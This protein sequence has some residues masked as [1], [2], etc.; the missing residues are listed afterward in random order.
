[1]KKHFTIML[2]TAIACLTLAPA[3]YART[4]DNC[5]PVSVSEPAALL[6]SLTALGLFVAARRRKAA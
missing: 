2:A 4:G 5:D 3:A 6:V 1:M